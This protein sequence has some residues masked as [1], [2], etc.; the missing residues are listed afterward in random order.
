MTI[1]N[2]P[3]PEEMAAALKA[4]DRQIYGDVPPPYWEGT[5]AE[6]REAAGGAES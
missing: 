3:V 5:V 1:R 4:I 6:W 2:E